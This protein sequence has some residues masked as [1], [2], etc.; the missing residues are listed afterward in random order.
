MVKIQLLVVGKVRGAMQQLCADYEQRIGRYFALE[1][2]AV[3]EESARRGRDLEEVRDEEARRLL[4]KVRPGYDVVALH[5]DGELWSSERLASF[6]DGLALHAR[7]GVAFC[8]GGAHGH[9]RSVLDRASLRLSLSRFILPHE[10]ARLVLT[11]QFYRA[12]T[13]LRGEPY[14]KTRD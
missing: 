3:R 13:I 9:G 7:P 1:A 5:H 14:H 8:I 10:V 12:G 11:E 4:A 2:V 6:L